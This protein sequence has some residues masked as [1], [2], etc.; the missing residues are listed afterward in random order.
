M[1]T[2]STRRW[3]LPVNIIT[4]IGHGQSINGRRHDEDI[5]LVVTTLVSTFGQYEW[6]HRRIIG[7][8][9]LARLH[10]AHWF[11]LRIYGYASTL[12]QAT[13]GG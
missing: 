10:M 5:G 6:R 4:S 1:N 2:L 11:T 12:E 8:L 7:A 13:R 9:L 3:S